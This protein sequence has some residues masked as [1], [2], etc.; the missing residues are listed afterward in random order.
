MRRSMAVCRIGADAAPLA[1][2]IAALTTPGDQRPREHDT[3]VYVALM[4]MGHADIVEREKTASGRFT[5]IDKR[6]LERQI[7][8]ASPPS[9]CM[10]AH[11]WPQ[12]PL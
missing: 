12:V 5:R 10:S 11:N 3:A 2:R 7:G 8:P 9:V 6:V 1:E 4:R